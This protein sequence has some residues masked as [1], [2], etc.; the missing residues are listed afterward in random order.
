MIVDGAGVA[1][2]TT[3][4]GG[5]GPTLLLTHGFGGERGHLDPLARRLVADHRIV[6][7]DMRNHGES[8]KGEWSW[9]LVLA[10]MAAVRDAY[11]LERPIV[12]GHSLGGMLGVLFAVAEPSTRAVINLD[13]HGQGKPHQY[14]GL[15]A[16]EVAAGRERL[17]DV[18]VALQGPESAE[19]LAMLEEITQLWMFDHYP[20]LQ[21]PALVYNAVGP[22]PLTN[23]EGNEWL[24][25]FMQSYRKG[26]GLD[27]A[28]LAASQPGFEVETIDATHY[29]IFG[30]A[31]AVAERIR[32][33]V[34]TLP[35]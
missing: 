1:I 24:L 14:F 35:N 21:C 6:T 11:G 4:H 12:G 34:A 28:A 25:P 3:D 5:D 13:G 18:Q 8:G 2:A 29:L 27:L 31:D 15:D 9:P 23:L 26:L 22:D 33:F 19:Q 17:H 32:R 7:F 30:A 20:Q 16:D 10:D